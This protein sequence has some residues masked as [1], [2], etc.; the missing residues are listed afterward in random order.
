V[1]KVATLEHGTVLVEVGNVHS[2][3]EDTTEGPLLDLAT[4][5][6]NRK[7]RL[8]N[9]KAR[10]DNLIAAQGVI[11]AFIAGRPASER[12]MALGAVLACLFA[13]RDTDHAQFTDLQAFAL[14]TLRGVDLSEANMDIVEDILVNKRV[15]D[16]WACSKPVAKLDCFVSH[17]WFDSPQDKAAALR[18]WGAAFAAR[19]GRAP[20][21]WIDL[22]CLEQTHEALAKSV[23]CLPIYLLACDRVL[24]LRSASLCSRLWCLTEA[25]TCFV[26]QLETSGAPAAGFEVVDVTPVASLP[27]RINVVHAKCSLASD[28]EA[29]LANLD[30]A[31]GGI[32][33]VE[34][35]VNQALGLFE[36]KMAKRASL[37]ASVNA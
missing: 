6:K 31:P 32:D 9:A 5:R 2:H 27:S 26:S 15:A 4:Q 36:V 10:V 13:G 17:S 35:V 28:Q 1:Y 14:R 24:L 19:E 20:V 37:A 8:L 18:K 21:A 30:R 7:Q 11:D 33:S 23:T 3:V 25:Y 29:L 34:T 16:A 12:K 22:F